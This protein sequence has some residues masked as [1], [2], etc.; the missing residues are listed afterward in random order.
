MS[1]PYHNDD[2]YNKIYTTDYHVSFQKSEGQPDYWSRDKDLV[3]ASLSRMKHIQ[4]FGITEGVLMDVGAGTGAL[5]EAA[6]LSGFIAEGVDPSDTICRE[7]QA[8]GR[9]IT[10]GDAYT[11]TGTG[12]DVIY[13]SDVFE[14]LIHPKD[15]L[16]H[17]WSALA[18]TG[19]LIIEMPEEG[20][21]QAHQQGMKWRHYRP[22]Q[23]VYLYTEGA[24][25]TLLERSG[26]YVEAVTRPLRGSLG[27]IVYYARKIIVT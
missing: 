19:M 27:K 9:D 12:Y 3:H 7:A 18:D 5:V 4:L 16:S 10:L 22:L 6:R 24:A 20:S 11:Y 26:Y 1:F 25:R 14:H 2:E 17:A 21:P 13:M 8:K 23:H 15:C